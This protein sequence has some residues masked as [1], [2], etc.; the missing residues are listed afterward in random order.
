MS[1]TSMVAR[2]AALVTD[3]AHAPQALAAAGWSIEDVRAAVAGQRLLSSLDVA[4]LSEA[5][6]VTPLWLITGEPDPDPVRAIA[7]RIWDEDPHPA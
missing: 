7:C 4:L 6:E 2:L 5:F 1:D 3:H